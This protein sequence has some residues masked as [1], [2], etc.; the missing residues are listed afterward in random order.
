MQ[1]GRNWS[2]EES[3]FEVRDSWLET[4]DGKFSAKL[5]EV[6]TQS[7]LSTDGKTTTTFKLAK[8]EAAYDP[9]IV[10]KLTP[11][12]L[13]AIPNVNTLESEVTY[14]VFEIADVSPMHYSMLSLTTS[15]PGALRG[16]FMGLIER[17]WKHSSKS[18]WVE[19][20][21]SPTGYVVDFSAGIKYE[22][23]Y[24]PLLVGSQVRLLNKEAVRQF[25]CYT[26]PTSK[27]P[28]G[29][30]IGN[31][32]GIIDEKVPF[33]IDFTQLINYHV[34]AFC[35]TGGGKSYLTSMVLRKALAAVEDLKVVV[36]D[37]SSEYGIHLLDQ[38][39]LLPSRVILPYEI[40]EEK[41]RGARS[42]SNNNSGNGDGEDI[43][44]PQ[45]RGGSKSEREKEL[46]DSSLKT[47]GEP[48]SAKGREIARRAEEYYKKHVVPETL[49]PRKEQ[50]LELIRNL[51]RE[52]KCKWLYT[53]PE[54]LSS[55]EK[56]RTYEGFL[57]SVAQTAAEK[58]NANQQASLYVI[59]KIQAF[60]NR[61]GKR[62]DSQTDGEVMPVL[63]EMLQHFRDSG[64]RSTSTIYSLVT[65]LLGRL[66]EDTGE[67]EEIGYSIDSL[68][69]EILDNGRDSP[70]LVV[71][72][73][74]TERSREIATMLIEKIFKK[75]R[76]S[77]NL[78]PRILFV[79]D[80]AQEFVPSSQTLRSSQEIAECNDAVERLLRHGRKYHLHGWIST[81]RLAHLNTNVLHQIHSY[82]VGTLPRPYDRQ[83]VGDTFA[84]DDA[85]LERT[86]NFASGDWLLASFKATQTQNVPV[87]F[88]A[89]NNE[90]MILPS[91]VAEDES[92]LLPVGEGE[93]ENVDVA[94]GSSFKPEL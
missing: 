26:P 69:E 55:V 72:N 60:L 77:F 33:T 40:G 48:A 9:D 16:E 90:E 30:C 92:G 36:I 66:N 80:E 37:V 70:R 86:L 35:H 14:S 85:L 10:R 58:Y 62:K 57:D 49:E 39:A 28:Q 2:E 43:D 41:A 21:A 93:Q 25:V 74:E 7:R 6:Y 79:F 44:A 54:Y 12:Q 88:H 64:V 82:F 67:P 71:I 3:A 53:K 89:L 13:L 34:G 68:V 73:E 76:T 51:F 8:V 83:L 42:S 45:E 24:A 22:R 47:I 59:D 5:R 63:N 91:V 19:I 31:L 20:L 38:L 84:I 1:G 56:Y 18:T 23:K 27:N 87:F 65:A 61:T 4:L 78:R 29:Y 17:E 46:V 50:L 52:D 15:Q 11:G 75:R 94:A 81:Q 32:L